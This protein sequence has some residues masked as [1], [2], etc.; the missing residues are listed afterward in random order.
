MFYWILATVAAYFVK[1]LCGFAN[2]L[3]FTSIL[4]FGVNNVNISP[5]EVVLGYPSNIILTWQNRKKLDKSLWLPLAVMV[6]VG[7]VPGALLLANMDARYIKIAFG[8]LVILLGIEMYLRDMGK[9]NIKESK[10]LL[11][12]IGLLSGVLCGLFGVGALL[13]AYVGRVTKASDTFKAN[14]SAVFVVDNTFRII[15]YAVLGVFTSETLKQ[16]ALL[17]PFML[18]GLFAGITGSKYLDEKFIRKLVILLLILSGI[19][20]IVKNI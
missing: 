10:W 2:T 17:M 16:S 1:G 19:A 12:I 5:V 20:L 14:M 9:T 7:S 8:V 11:G 4:G 6:V 13:A 18:I 3:V 15:L